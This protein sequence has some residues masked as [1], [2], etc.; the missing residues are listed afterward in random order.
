M[1]RRHI[2]AR[3]PGYPPVYALSRGLSVLDCVVHISDFS[4]RMS[5]VAS[6]NK[7]NVL[8]LAPICRCWKPPGNWKKGYED[9]MR[10]LP[11]RPLPSNWM[12]GL[13]RWGHLDQ[14]TCVKL[15]Q[16]CPLETGNLRLFPVVTDRSPLSWVCRR[17]EQSHKSF[18]ASSLWLS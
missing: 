15:S 7:R 12:R 9:G 13:R 4:E 11:L 14:I 18:N 17:Q 3:L 10:L 8:E 2:S 16:L 5:Q 1:R 6:T